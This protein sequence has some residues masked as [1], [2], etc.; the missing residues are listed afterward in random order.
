M[1]TSFG[2]KIKMKRLSPEISSYL[3]L[4]LGIAAPVADDVIARASNGGLA[5]VGLMGIVLV[6]I[7]GLML[8]AWGTDDK[9][10]TSSQK[11]ITFLGVTL[12][13]ILLLG[14]FFLLVASGCGCILSPSAKLF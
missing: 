9:K 3:S 11:I 12:N 5:R 1:A 10:S 6:S 2:F 13:A 4:G 7:I 8:G 14:A